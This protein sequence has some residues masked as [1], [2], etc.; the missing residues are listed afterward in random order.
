[1]P[2]PGITF[3]LDGRLVTAQPGET[4]LS[5]AQRHG[6]EIPHLCH[7]DG[8]RPDGNCRACV[9][10]IA[11]ERTLA[12]SC[13]RAPAPGMKVPRA[14]PR[15]RKSQEMVL[16]LLLADMP[17][18]GHKWNDGPVAASGAPAPSPQSGRTANSAP[19]R[20]PGRH[21]APGAHRLRRE[22]PA[23][24]CHPA[25]AVN[26]DACI[27]CN[28][29]VRACREE[30]VND[31][32]G[33]AR[34]ARTA[35]RVRPGRPHGCQ[36]L[37]GLRRMRAGLPHRRADAQDADRLAGGGPPGRFGLPVLRRGL[38]DHLQRARDKRIVSVDGRDGPA[39]QGPP[40]RQGALR[41]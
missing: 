37:R 34:G 22:Q 13:C 15:A 14:S 24:T 17:E 10:E 11:G 26:L 36:H 16:E 33:Y 1:L 18:R 29:C 31:V 27:Q 30:Q 7:S 19:G 21:R 4:I 41:F 23:P 39:N 9:V 2:T 32:I 6:V 20:A 12:P 3:E 8:L 38:P 28:R 25:M 5:A 40:V 35:D